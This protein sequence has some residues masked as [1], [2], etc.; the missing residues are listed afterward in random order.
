MDSLFLFVNDALDIPD[1]AFV[2]PSRNV[3]LP[4]LPSEIKNKLGIDSKA[5]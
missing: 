1:E 4:P 3:I 5:Y 2:N